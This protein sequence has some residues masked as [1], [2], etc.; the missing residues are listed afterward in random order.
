VVDD[1][2]VLEHEIGARWPNAEIRRVADPQRSHALAWTVEMP[3]GPVDAPLRETDR[4]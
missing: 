3:N 4:P 2:D 1:V